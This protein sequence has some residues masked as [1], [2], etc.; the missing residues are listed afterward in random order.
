MNSADLV[1]VIQ[2]EGRNLVESLFGEFR[3]NLGTSHYHR[4]SNEELFRRG[5]AVYQ[6]LASW[7]KTQDAAAAHL[8]GEQLGKQRFAEGIPLGQVVLALIL[9]EKHLW[10]Y[11]INRGLEADEK[12]R[13]E[14][15][16]FFARAIYSTALGY[17]AALS[18][19]NRGGQRTAV[20]SPAAGAGGSAPPSTAEQ[21]EISPSRSGQVGEFG[22]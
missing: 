20:S 4:L 15:A 1:R 7:L 22:G 11:T 6:N 13:M 5:Y 2:E 12:L 3:S 9:E 18:E 16:E 19:S 8:A 14:V 21:E 17:E 10:K